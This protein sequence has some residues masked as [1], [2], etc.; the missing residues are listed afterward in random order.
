MIQ[1]AIAGLAVGGMYAVLAVCLTL[2]SRLVRVVNFSQAAIGMFGAFV[3]VWITGHGMPLWAAT[4]I[5]ILIGGALSTIVGW[6]LAK[7]MSEADV[8]RRSAVTV[9]ALLLLISMSFILFG[10]RPQAFRPILAGAA[11]HLGGVVIS[12]VTVTTVVMAIVIAVASWLLLVQTTA[13]TKLRALSER[14]TT[15]E[16]LGIPART[17]SISVWAITGLI[18]TLAI[19]LVAPTQ[20]NDA[21]GLSMLIVPAA[22]AALL[23]AFKRLDLAV[24]GGLALGVIQGALAQFSSLIVLR[25]FVPIVIIVGL[26]LWLQRK[27]VWDEAR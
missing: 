16:L 24:I 21:A 6:I 14:P 20:S 26:L 15:A 17:L 4:V 18:S 27:E 7:W 10:N 19:S 12:Q 11:F 5:G 25:Y 2:M 1:G 23:G 9:G 13:G 3:A 8:G 22:A